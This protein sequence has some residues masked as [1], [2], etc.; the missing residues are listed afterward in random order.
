MM[1][2]VYIWSYIVKEM[3]ISE[4]KHNYGPSGEWVKFFKRSP[5]Y[6]KTELLIDQNNPFRLITIDYWISQESYFQFINNFRE[7]YNSIDKKCNKFTYKE[8]KIGEFARE[9][10]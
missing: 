4:F 5:N 2:F 8:E 3:L 10:E 1:V 7:E 6:L 9:E